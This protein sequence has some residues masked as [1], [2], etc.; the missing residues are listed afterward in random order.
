[1]ILW[2]RGINVDDDA[3]TAAGPEDL[4][5]DPD[6]LYHRGIQIKGIQ[7]LA[8]IIKS[9]ENGDWLESCQSADWNPE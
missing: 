6:T 4:H 1:M 5:I 8:E 2:K 7:N 3:G 9:D